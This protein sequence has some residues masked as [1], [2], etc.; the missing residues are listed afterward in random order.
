MVVQI[1]KRLAVF[2][3]TDPLQERQFPALHMVE[4]VAKNFLTILGILVRIEDMIV[5]KCID[6]LVRH[7]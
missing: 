6:Y 4:K 5:P 3:Q 2:L 1:Q 7:D